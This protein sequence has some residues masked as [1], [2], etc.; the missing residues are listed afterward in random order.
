MKLFSFY[1]K[2][3]LNEIYHWNIT[4]DIL[5]PI[6]DRFWC[7]NITNCSGGKERDHVVLNIVCQ[8]DKKV[9]RVCLASRRQ[10]EPGPFIC[11]RTLKDNE[12]KIIGN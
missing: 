8:S 2:I 1:L 11:K 10:S 6:T 7:D 3:G 9:P 5:T 4:G 12:G